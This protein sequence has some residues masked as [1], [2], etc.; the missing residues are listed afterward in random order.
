MAYRG[1]Q[2]VMHT[3][4]TTEASR[5]IEIAAFNARIERGEITRIEVYDMHPPPQRIDHLL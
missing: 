4:H 1:R 2:L 3:W 5:D